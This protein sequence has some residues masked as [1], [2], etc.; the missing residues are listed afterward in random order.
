MHHKTPEDTRRHGTEVEDQQL[1]SG[2]SRPHH[3]AAWLPCGILPHPF[4]VFLH[5]LLGC[6]SAIRE[7]GLIQGL[8][9]LPQDYKYRR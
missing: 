9:D 8:T 2:A 5:R 7:I 3:H 1:P 6:I 4:G